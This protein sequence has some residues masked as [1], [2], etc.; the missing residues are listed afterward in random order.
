MTTILIVGATIGCLRIRDALSAQLDGEPMGMRASEVDSHLAGCPDCVAWYAAAARVTRLA[1]VAPAAPTPDLTARILAASG[2]VSPPRRYAMTVAR[3]ALALIGLAQAVLAVPALALGADGMHPP[4]HVAHE[5][6]AWNLALAVAFVAAAMRP[7]SA[8]GLLP[9]L[10]AFVAALVV[11][12]VPDL[13]TADVPAL[14]LAEHLPAV[15]ALLL[16]A[17][18]AR[19]GRRPRVPPRRGRS[20]GEGGLTADTG[21]ADTGSPVVLQSDSDGA[22]G[23]SA[24]VEGRVSDGYAARVQASGHVA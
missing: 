8:A 3:V 14:R 22:V 1:R 10:G 4:M 12:S 21:G 13:A 20:A 2:R 18:L 11:V 19:G 5:G 16:V 9:V 17:V 15:I 7:R 24:A 23:G 6:G